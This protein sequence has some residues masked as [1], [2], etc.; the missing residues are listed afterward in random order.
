ML[1]L[2]AVVVVVVVAAVVRL[3]VSLKVLS[4]DMNSAQSIEHTV[5]NPDKVLG[6]LQ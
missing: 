4:D 6:R 3:V 5:H 1:V 2:L